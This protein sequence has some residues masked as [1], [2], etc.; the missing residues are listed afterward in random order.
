M[1]PLSRS[2]L[3]LPSL[4]ISYTP[5][6]PKTLMHPSISSKS[7]QGS[8]EAL[9]FGP[10]NRWRAEG[11]SEKSN[12]SEG[13]RVTTPHTNL[14]PHMHHGYVIAM[15]LFASSFLSP[16]PPQQP[17]CQ[18][19]TVSCFMRFYQNTKSHFKPGLKFLVKG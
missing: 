4:Q 14:R 17:A 10:P 16:F 8:D 7:H 18:A 1:C 6:A 2:P 12:S 19:A 13:V 11:A 5:Q 15:L 9:G 3:H